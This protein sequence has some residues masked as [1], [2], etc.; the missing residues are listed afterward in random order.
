MSIALILFIINL[1]L[2]NIIE[3]EEY[4]M[5][6]RTLELYKDTISSVGTICFFASYLFSL[7]W[8]FVSF[9]YYFKTRNIIR[10]LPPTSTAMEGIDANTRIMNAFRQ[11]CFIIFVSPFISGLTWVI[12]YGRT[13]IKTFYSMLDDITLDFELH[14]KELARESLILLVRNMSN[15][16]LFVQ[17]SDKS[18]IQSWPLKIKI[19][20]TISLVYVIW[21]RNNNAL[22]IED[23]K[24]DLKE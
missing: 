18:L 3:I 11:S 17:D 21:I 4:L 15:V 1:I 5:Q 10:K 14:D 24:G 8:Y 6:Y 9:I 20:L 19:Y 7:V 2:N 12:T 16:L 22:V 23:E 13:A